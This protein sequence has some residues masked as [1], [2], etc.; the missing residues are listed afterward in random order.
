MILPHIAQLNR[1]RL[2]PLAPEPGAR[3]LSPGAGSGG[4]GSA[5]AI[6]TEHTVTHDDWAVGDCVQAGITAL[7]ASDTGTKLGGIV[8]EVV[9][10]ETTDTITV[11][12]WGLWEA[13]GSAG[14]VY[15]ADADGALSVT[16]PTADLTCARI[17]AVQIDAERRLVQPELRSWT[18][19]EVEAC[20]D[21]EDVTLRV[22]GEEV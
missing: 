11:T 16:A 9:A 4:G 17:M 21:G 8:T 13:G 5:G 6:T 7:T 1:S 18:I 22:Y 3:V 19:L 20:L 2:A 12:W 10:G 14:A 15:Y